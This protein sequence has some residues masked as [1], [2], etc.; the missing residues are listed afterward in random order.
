[1][2]I[3]AEPW[4][5]EA[6]EA[7]GRQ[8]VK[9][10]TSVIDALANGDLNSANDLSTYTLPPYLV[11]TEC[12][13]VWKFRSDQIK[14]DPED[15]LWVTR[16]VVDSETGTVVG[17][18]GYHGRPDKNGMVEVGYAIDTLHRRRGHARA[19]FKILLDMAKVD[20][21]IKVIRASVR[22]DNLASR[23][24]TDQYG[25]HKVGEQWDDEDGLEVV[26]ELS[27]S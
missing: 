9:L 18:A 20:P 21:E 25:L 27:V 13:G 4:I 26:L 23:G 11:G 24:L 3:T 6:S 12:I 2:S 16:L 8:L 19:A 10:P 5:S 14:V 22:P 1:M 15:A 7:A 17:R